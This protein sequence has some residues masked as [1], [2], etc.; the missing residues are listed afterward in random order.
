MQHTFF[1]DSSARFIRTENKAQRRDDGLSCDT[2]RDCSSVCLGALQ[3]KDVCAHTHTNTSGN[4]FLLWCRAQRAALHT[5][6]LDQS[7]RARLATAPPLGVALSLSRYA[8]SLV[9]PPTRVRFSTVT[10]PITFERCPARRLSSSCSRLLPWWNYCP[11]SSIYSLLFVYNE[12]S[13][14]TPNSLTLPP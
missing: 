2:L 10:L 6:S 3:R 12:A 1:I 8:L 13:V 4:T 9:L 11:S 5:K 14:P 7:P